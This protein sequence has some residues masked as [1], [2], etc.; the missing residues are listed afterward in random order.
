M[1]DRIPTP[2]QEGRVLI[3]PED[4]SPAFYATVQ[5]ADNPS[6]TGTAWSVENVLQ[7]GT[8]Q[9]LGLPTSAVPNDAFAAIPRVISQKIPSTFQLLM[10]G[11][12]I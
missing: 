8:C 12:L 2:G 9:I 4:G 7:N 1:Q 3:T 5:M 11:R 10:T 6:Q